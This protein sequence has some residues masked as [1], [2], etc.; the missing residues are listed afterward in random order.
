M[1]D[2]ADDGDAAHGDPAPDDAGLDPAD[3]MGLGGLGGLG[4][5]LA[6][7]TGALAAQQE[8]ADTVV[9][10]TAG[11]GMVRIEMTGDHD[12]RS[13]T[14]DP[15][16]VDPDETELLGDLVLAALRDAR[17]RADGLTAAAFG[18]LDLG[19][20]GLD[21]GGLDLGGLDLGGL[22]LGGL[23]PGGPDRGGSGGAA[24]PGGPG[25]PAG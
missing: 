3:P 15:S 23:G 19:G 4:D 24:D 16:V 11:G 13:V 6:Q 12:V 25:G 9:E 7:A 18:G 2:Q 1:T 10:G 8:A 21:L 5:L 20:L 22:D 17:A 14:I